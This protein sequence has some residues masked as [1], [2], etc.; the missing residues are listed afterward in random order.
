MKVLEY[1][2]GKLRG[3]LSSYKDGYGYKIY[4]KNIRKSQ[5]IAQSYVY[6]YDITICYER[7][8]SEMKMLAEMQKDLFD[9][10]K[11]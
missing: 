3:V 11:L 5:I 7:M 6:L 10:E 8:V 2:L 1:K 9:L 4:F